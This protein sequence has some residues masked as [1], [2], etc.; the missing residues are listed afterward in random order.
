MPA[1]F[2]F[3]CGASLVGSARFCAECGV[4]QGVGIE[5]P[6]AQ[7]NAR[8]SEPKQIPTTENPLADSTAIA[9]TAGS[10]TTRERRW[11]VRSLLAVVVCFVAVGMVLGS[12]GYFENTIDGVDRGRV[13]KWMQ[14]QADAKRAAE[15]VLRRMTAATKA[16]DVPMA[17]RICENHNRGAIANLDI[18]MQSPSKAP[19]P[20]LQE[21]RIMPRWKD[22]SRISTCAPTATF[23]PCNCVGSR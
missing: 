8:P 7:P 9:Q 19:W 17:I 23:R 15:E 3:Q 5:R 13:D 2:C 16:G 14:K 1:K 10:V 6:V 20:D 4:E 21:S 18:W 11:L 12:S 22:G